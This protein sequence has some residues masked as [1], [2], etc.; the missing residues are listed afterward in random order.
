[1]RATFPSHVVCEWLGN[2]EDIAR[3]HYYQMTDDHFAQANRPTE[4]AAAK[5]AAQNAIKCAN[6]CSR[7]GMP[8]AAESRTKSR[9]PLGRMQIAR[10]P[11]GTCG[12]VR[13]R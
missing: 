5:K 11:A 6:R 10:K 9:N 13:R 1:M 8:V 4:K 2:S 3:K 12:N 7:G